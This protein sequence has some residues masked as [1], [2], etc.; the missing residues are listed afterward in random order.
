[1]RRPNE[2]LP[3]SGENV[4]EVSLTDYDQRRHDQARGARRE[5]YHDESDDEEGPGGGIPQGVQCASH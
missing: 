2:N 4:E 5:A 3:V 1:M